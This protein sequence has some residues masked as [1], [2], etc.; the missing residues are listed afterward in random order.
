MMDMSDIV[1]RLEKEGYELKM[2]L[3]STD[4]LYAK[5]DK[6]IIYDSKS[7]KIVE[8]YVSRL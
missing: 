5:G 6:R 2:S 8:A 1:K 4:K 3:C 7:D